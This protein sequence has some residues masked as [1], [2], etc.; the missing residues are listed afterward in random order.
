M[1][2]CLCAVLGTPLWLEGDWRSLTLAEPCS[3]RAAAAEAW[4][5]L[6]A[7]DV[8]HYERVIE[9]LEVVMKLLPRLVSCIKHMKILYGFKTLVSASAVTFYVDSIVVS[10]RTSS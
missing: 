7:R 4:A 5:V 3:V 8:K 2:V 1:C 6:K 10:E 9:F